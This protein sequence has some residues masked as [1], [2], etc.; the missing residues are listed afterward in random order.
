MALLLPIKDDKC[1]VSVRAHHYSIA[2]APCLPAPCLLLMPEV[3]LSLPFDRALYLFIG[4][5]VHLNATTE[6]PWCN[7]VLGT[8]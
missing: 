6:N 1:T 5:H 4:E 3:L 2:K 8:I 7:C